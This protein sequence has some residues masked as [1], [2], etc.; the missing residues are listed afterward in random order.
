MTG[1]SSVGAVVNRSLGVKRSSVSDDE[2]FNDCLDC[3]TTKSERRALK[4]FKGND[5]EGFRKRRSKAVASELFGEESND[6]SVEEV[7]SLI[8]SALQKVRDIFNDDKSSKRGAGSESSAGEQRTADDLDAEICASDVPERMQLR[9]VP[10]TAA[11]KKELAREARWIYEQAFD[12]RTISIQDSHLTAEAKGRARKGPEAVDKIAVALDLLKNQHLEVPFIAFY[13]KECVL[14]ELGINDL[15]RIY[16]FDAKWCQLSRRKKALLDVFQLMKYHQDSDASRHSRPIESDDIEQ[17]RAARTIEELN[18]FYQ[19]FFLHYAPEI[20]KEER[21]D[22]RN[23]SYSIYREAGLSSLARKF[24]LSPK[25]FA[26]NLDRQCQVHKVEQEAVLPSVLALSYINKTFK[27]SE[28]VLKAAQRMVAIQISKEPMVR[29]SVRK[30]YLEQAKMSVRPT[31]KGIAAIGENHPVYTMKYLKGKPVKDLAGDQYLKLSMAQ[32]D[33]LITIGFSDQVE[34]NY[35]ERAKR[36]WCRSE[37]SKHVR[38]WDRLRA[39]SVEAAVAEMLVPELKRE[40]H[41]TLLA[42]AKECV[43]RCCARKIYD[44][45]KTAPYRAACSAEHEDCWDAS[46]GLRVMGVA[47]DDDPAATA[48]F[49]CT[50]APSAACADSYELPDAGTTSDGAIERAIAASRPH[51]VAISGASCRAPAIARAFREAIARLAAEANFP[52]IAVEIVENGAALVYSTNSQGVAEFPEH[53]AVLRQA[54]SLAR[55]LQDPLGEL[56]QL[57]NADH[58]ILRLEL[59]DLQDQ[60]AREDLRDDIYLE[61]V[62]RVNEVGVDV[63]RALLTPY[64]GSLLQFV[65]GFGPRKARHLLDTLGRASQ[66]LEDRRQLMTL[67][68]LGPKMY[69]NCAGFIKIDASSLHTAARARVQVLDGSRVHPE[70]YDWVGRIAA[71]ALDYDCQEASAAPLALRDIVQVPERLQE[72]DL[73]AYAEELVRRGFPNQCITLH[74]IRS[75]LTHRYKDLRIPYQ[76]PTVDQLFGIFAKQDAENFYVGKLVEA[77]I[78]A[79]A[80][81]VVW[82]RLDNSISGFIRIDNLSDE[83]VANPEEKIRVGDRIHC[84][85]VQIEAAEFRVEASSKHSDLADRNDEWRLPKDKY[86]DHIA[87]AR[88]ELLDERTRNA[89]QRRG[90]ATRTSAHCCFRNVNF[91]DAEILMQAMRPGE[92]IIRPSSKGEGQLCLTW[93]MSEGVNHHTAV[94]DDGKCL[95]IGEQEFPNVDAIIA[96]HVGPMAVYACELMSFKHY[97]P[98]VLGVQGKAE[99]ILKNQKR[100]NPQGI[101][102]II[103]AIKNQPGKFMLSYLPR[104]QC[105]HSIITISPAGLTF[106]GRRFDRLND[107]IRWFKEHSKESIAK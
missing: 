25:Q 51:V 33:R 86:Y 107:F 6:E 15:W 4:R 58:E 101:P 57:C 14:P 44:W 70:N 105:R 102:Y 88:D 59:H 81:E 99:E 24:G 94:R 85:I 30:L 84:R 36:L 22:D 75:E 91:K 34:A 7:V 87:E 96:R 43:T 72:L 55:R 8:R 3:E 13:R 31:S 26:N 71:D 66:Q 28:E 77:T 89:R 27:T 35:A 9:V 45:I 67:C 93:K 38:E 98:Q 56:S 62:N 74:D 32:D 50:V 92:V 17:L 76:S 82:L 11:S 104:D 90:D 29:K 37:S 23:E 73:D 16:K 80:N 103:S 78:V 40:L 95:W 54:I 65:C 2:G 41:S 83:S 48:A 49:A 60:V 42:E 12:C 47:Y 18:D 39:G 64:F 19:L 53:P 52:R 61:F 20:F 69:A 21:V 5:D 10:V 68:R 1:I 97:K 106:G 46:T 100:K 79:L 63:N